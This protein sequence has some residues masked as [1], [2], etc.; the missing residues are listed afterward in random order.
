M[1]AFVTGATGFLGSR[2]CG[3]LRARGDDVTVL[4]RT[5]AKA[6][7]LE[8]IGC[9]LVEG[10]LSDAAA[11]AEGVEGNEAVF[12]VAAMYEIGV[13]GS[14]KAAMH[15]AN[16]VGTERVLNAAVA[17]NVRRIVYVSTV[18]VFGNTHGQVVDE[19][20]RRR[21]EPFLSAYDETK[22]RAHQ[23]AQRKI[24]QG[25]PIVIAQPSMIYGPG[26]HSEVG[27][28]IDEALQGKLHYV[29]FPNMGF[30]SVHVDDVAQGILLAYD[31]G[32]IGES[33]ILGGEVTTMKGLIAKAS[34]AAGRKPPKVVMPTFMVKMAVPIGPYVGKSMG[35]PPNLRELIRASDGV[36]Y[37]ASDD[38]ARRELGYSPRSLA[39]GLKTMLL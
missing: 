1:K 5:P 38:K 39:E 24:A 27:R 14:R 32:K 36:T 8:D 26:D 16:V 10:D 15:E 21:D 19:D 7:V 18:G 30:N 28:V 25:A 29:A 31:K 2:L 12:H 33:Y 3:L 35:L 4:V 6:K 11:V 13:P 23:I 34:A 22:F 37:W 9:R 20:Y 17:A